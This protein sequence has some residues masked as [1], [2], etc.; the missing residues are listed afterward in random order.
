MNHLEGTVTMPLITFQKLRND[1][2][3]IFSTHGKESEKAIKQ[4][5]WIMVNE[6]K[7]I[8]LA[9]EELIRRGVDVSKYDKD[10]ARYEFGFVVFDLKKGAEDE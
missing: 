5:I 7:L 9:W 10:S 1:T 2:S 6:Q 3:Q 4:G 8:E